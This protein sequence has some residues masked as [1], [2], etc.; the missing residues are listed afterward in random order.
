M[1]APHPSASLRVPGYLGR[2]LDPELAAVGTCFQASPGILVTAWHV[3]E[4]IGA[5]HLGAEVGIDPLAGGG[6][7]HGEVAALDAVHDLAVIRAPEALAASVAGWSRSDDQRVAT[8]LV[9]TGAPEVHDVHEYRYLDARGTW[10]GT[11]LR[12]EVPLGRAKAPDVLPGMSGAPVRRADDD[13]VIGVLSARYNSVDGWLRHTVWI[14]R[15]EDLAPLL[16]GIRPMVFSPR[17]PPPPPA[18]PRPLPPAAA[19]A[20]SELHLAV[21]KDISDR[22]RTQ[23]L[24]RPEPLTLRWQ[25]RTEMFPARAGLPTGTARSLAGELTAHT[26]NELAA[27]W[28]ARILLAEGPRHLVVLGEAGAGKTT[29]AVLLVRALLEE[30]NV[31][32][33]LVSVA[34]WDPGEPDEPGPTVEDDPAVPPRGRDARAGGGEEFTAWFARRITEICPTIRAHCDPTD[35]FPASELLPVLD[36][37]DEMPRHLRAAAIAHLDGLDHRLVLTS[38]SAEFEEASARGVLSQAR[39]IEIER[40]RPEDAVRYLTGRDRENERHRWQKVRHAIEHG[41]GPLAEVLST[42]LMISLA[43][44][45]YDGPNTRP[46]ELAESGHTATVKRTLLRR[47]L[48]SVYP[49]P[50]E[51][52]RAARWLTFLAREMRRSQG[53]DPDFYWWRL[54]RAVPRPV[55]ALLYTLS[56][57]VLGAGAGWLCAALGEESRPLVPVLLAGAAAGGFL[58]SLSGVIA[59]RTAHT[60]PPPPRPP[61]R[62]VVVSSLR[63]ALSAAAVTCALIAVLL[64]GLYAAAPSEAA[65]INHALWEWWADLLDNEYEEAATLGVYLM[66]GIG[67]AVVGTMLDAARHGAPHHSAPRTADL[68]PALAP[69]FGVGAL[70]DVPVVAVAVAGGMRADETA[71]ACLVLASAVAVALGLGR[72]LARPLTPDEERSPASVLRADRRATLIIA[73]VPGAVVTAVV[74]GI[75]LATGDPLTTAAATGVAFGAGIALTVGYGS[76]S[77][78]ITFVLAHAWLTAWRRVP[79]RLFRA[80]R[81]AQEA[82]VL[83]PAGAAHQFRHDEVR[84]HLA[85][86]GERTDAPTAVTARSPEPGGARFTGHPLFRSPWL[87]GAARCSAVLVATGS[88]VG[89]S[90]YIRSGAVGDVYPLPGSLSVVSGLCFSPDGTYLAVAEHDRTRPRIFRVADHRAVADS[91]A[92][93]PGDSM[94]VIACDRDSGTVVTGGADGTVR[95]YDFATGRRTGPRAADVPQ[96]TQAHSFG[97]ALSP[98]QGLLAIGTIEEDNTEIT[99]WDMDSRR[100]FTLDTHEDNPYLL[101]ALSPTE[102]LLVSVDSRGRVWLWD[103]RD[104]HPSP[105]ALQEGLSGVRGLAFGQDGTTLATTG[106][107]RQV[108]L[109][110]VHTKKVTASLTERDS[111]G[112]IAISPQGDLA[113]GDYSGNVRVWS[114]RSRPYAVKATLPVGDVGGM[115]MAFSGDGHTLATANWHTDLTLWSL[116]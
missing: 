83:R 12:D 104:P 92:V 4:G 43:R 82:G 86:A 97:E 2:V 42:P 95:R 89:A 98:A 36:G 13:L 101:L 72:W 84:E 9:I 5:H 48:T 114:L 30:P 71:A 35:L 8:D 38:R 65:V 60:R 27:T 77:A 109:W 39:G 7:F 52:R 26:G 16:Q 102:Q 57:A 93:L 73:G 61:F 85:L 33:V 112:Q 51:H 79:A 110:N 53:R 31:V 14:P 37:L 59:G 75:V 10:E 40:V 1:N 64:L 111:V 3:L 24:H 80:L 23:W 90:L 54:A 113:V 49:V 99:V 105:V 62:A 67:C 81:G 76:G 18:P 115:I 103:L 56:A 116:P 32:P 47:Y 19:D 68:L 22:V 28:L 63:D 44:K 55:I 69:A 108:R 66:V 87:S 106:P 58:G 17:R 94:A 70:V 78:W 29:L 25:D 88:L 6:A 74:S 96:A 50:A 46:A 100:V 15:T 41:E 107:G 11:T 21:K 34:G 91:G 45:A 20:L